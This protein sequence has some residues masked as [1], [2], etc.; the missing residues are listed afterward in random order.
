[1]RLRD[2]QLE[3]ELKRVDG[4]LETAQRQLDAVRATRTNRAVRG[5]DAVDGYRLSA[6]E[7]ELDQQL[8]NLRAEQDLLQRE[9]AKLVVN[10]PLAG[11]VLTWDVV[12]RLIARP[13]ERGDVLVTVADL[14]A[15]WNLELDVP[16]DGIGHVMAAREALRPDLPVEFRLS[17]DDRELHIGHIK[18]IS[19][20]ADVGEE[21]GSTPEPTVLVKVAFDEDA[22]GERARQGLRPGVSARAQIACGRRALGYVWLHDIWDAVVG[23]LRF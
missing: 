7:R 13:V 15:D 8:T 6:E 23:W 18:Q 20:I 10:S 17:S 19:M 11:R 2:P 4:E 5:A 21:D 22:L 1:V 3:L 16:D 12:N 14:S 9:R